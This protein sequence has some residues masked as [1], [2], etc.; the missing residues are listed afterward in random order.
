MSSPS[1]FRAVCADRAT[2]TESPLARRT[3]EVIPGRA[4]RYFGDGRGFS[5]RTIGT[6][7]VAGL[8]A[9]GTRTSGKK[10]CQQVLTLQN[11]A[12]VITWRCRLLGEVDAPVEM[13]GVAVD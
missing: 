2:L 11:P 10:P 4:E 12:G 1:E 13:A 8:A 7:E 3:R 9:R 5:G 6:G